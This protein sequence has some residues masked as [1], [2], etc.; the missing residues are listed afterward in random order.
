MRKIRY[1]LIFICI[2]FSLYL[3][4]APRRGCRLS[5]YPG[6][7]NF[8]FTITDDPDDSSLEKIKPIYEFLDRIGLKTTIACWVFKPEE[9]DGLPDP[10]EQ[11][12]SA[13]LEDERYL[14]FLRLCQSR[15]FELALHTVTSGHDRR[16][17]TIKGYDRFKELFGAYPKMNIMHSKNKENIY[18][19]KQVFHNTLM[20]LLVGVYTK[21][22][23]SGEIPE[24]RY[25]WGDIC[26]ERTKYVRLWGTSDINT[27]KFNPSMPYFDPAKP[28][29]NYWFSFSDGYK[30]V[31]F[32]RL[33]TD[34][35]I[36]TLVRERGACIVYTHFAAGFTKKQKDGAYLLNPAAERQL[37]KIASQKDGWFVPASV[38]LDRLLAMKNID[39]HETACALVISNLNDSEVS[40]ITILTDPRRLMYDARGR[41]YAANGEGEIVI[42]D[43]AA[44]EAFVLFK[45]PRVAYIYKNEPSRLEAFRLMFERIKIMMSHRG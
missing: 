1:I 43:V 34:A 26:K 31:Y 41:D 4:F 14:N 17:L 22:P 45:K 29:V 44:N 12:N 20:K 7:K 15:G 3:F 30:A 28:Y 9:V 2:L 27:L 35:R 24:S 13:T 37:K 38:V 39:L 10:R 32:N 6:G 25:F 16:E 18:W 42:P 21:M 36:N 33:V 40:G 5:P 23:F 8:A 19:G 11:Y